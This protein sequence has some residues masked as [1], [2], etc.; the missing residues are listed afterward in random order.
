MVDREVATICGNVRIT[1][2]DNQMNG[3]CAEVEMNTG[4]SKSD[5]RRGPESLILPT[6]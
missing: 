2:G 1:R 3:E 6:E 4:V 5:G